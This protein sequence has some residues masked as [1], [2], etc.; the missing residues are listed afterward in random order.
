M[1][2][3]L[4]T[5]LASTMALAAFSAAQAADAIDQVPEAPIANDPIA[6]PVGNW[7]GAYA[8]ATA[9]YNMGRFGAQKDYNARAFGGSVYGGYNMQ[10]DKIVYGAEADLGY[11]GNDAKIDATHEGKQNANGSIRG[12]VG[13]DLNPVLVYGTAG[14]AASNNK[15]SDATSSQDKTALGYTVGAGVEGFVTDKITARVEYRYSDYQAKNYN[16]ASGSGKVDF[17]DHSVKVGVGMKF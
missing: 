9:S 3:I 14:L 5:L 8:G 16:L 11:S 2:T 10:S 15:V 12:R 6:A 1:R 4:A 17:D 13:Y 7:A